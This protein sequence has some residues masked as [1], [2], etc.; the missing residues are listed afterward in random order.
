MNLSKL[1]SFLFPAAILSASALLACGADG[2]AEAKS[3]DPRAL[4][5]ALPQ[6]DRDAWGE[7]QEL[8]SFELLSTTKGNA[9][10]SPHSINVAM[11]MVSNGAGGN[12]LAEIEK[13]LHFLPQ[14]KLHQVMND[15]SLAL[16]SRATV[17]GQEVFALKEANRIFS[18]Q[19]LAVEDPF[20]STLARYYGASVGL[21]DFVSDAKGSRDL[22]NGWVREVTDSHI[23]DLLPE[24]AINTDTRMVLINAIYLEAKWSSPF[25]KSSTRDLPFAAPAGSVQVPTMRQTHEY[26]YADSAEGEMVELPYKGRLV[27]D[28]V[29]PKVGKTI[30]AAEFASLR[31]SLKTTLVDLALPKFAIRPLESL[32]LK[33]ALQDLG[34]KQAFETSAD[35]SGISS[36]ERLKIEDV[37]HRAMVDVQEDG[38]VASA[39]T[40]VVAVD[41]GAASNP[42]SATV[43]RVDRPFQFA[44]RDPST[45]AVLFIGRVENPQN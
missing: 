2:F 15:V 24:D 13:G 29:I 39:A 43:V 28:I 34:I 21:A 25:K 40:A 30:G 16:A 11:S 5:S 22:M 36:A 44:L 7:G 12:T 19:T 35:F 9:A 10:L 1:V 23:I 42:P 17:D 37:I 41:A 3:E 27:M 6:S 26:L 8:L 38:T 20:L 33:R 32:R 31:S 18:E 14:D 4:A 45:R